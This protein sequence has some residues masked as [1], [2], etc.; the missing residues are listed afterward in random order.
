M[1]DF[2]ERSLRLDSRNWTQ[3]K[4]H[5]QYS[6]GTGGERKRVEAAYLA[7]HGYREVDRL[8]MGDIFMVT[9]AQSGVTVEKRAE[10]AKKQ[11][12]LGERVVAAFVVL[13]ALAALAVFTGGP[14]GTSRPG[15]TPVP[16]P[17]PEARGLSQMEC[18]LIDRA[19]QGAVDASDLERAHDLI[20]QYADGGC[21]D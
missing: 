3:P 7:Q 10:G 19:W 9:Y 12:T 1:E 21:W 4:V 11:A 8:P 13:G 16:R 20:D 15:P 17:A 6:V 5:R 18:D 14:S 2:V